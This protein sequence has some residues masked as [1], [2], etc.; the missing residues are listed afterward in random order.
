MRGRRT[1]D[2]FPCRDW[3]RVPVS[4]RTASVHCDVSSSVTQ[5][6]ESSRPLAGRGVCQE[7][8][9][10]SVVPWDSTSQQSAFKRPNTARK[11]DEL[12]AG[13]RLLGCDVRP[14]L[15]LDLCQ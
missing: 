11:E 12:F 2:A 3:C 5:T 9:S 1:A 13:K 10:F 7:H 8:C 6:Q 4:G 15:L 14:V